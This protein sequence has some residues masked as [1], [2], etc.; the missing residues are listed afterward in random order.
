MIELATR[1]PHHWLARKLGGKQPLPLS[2]TLGLTYNCNAKCKTCDVHSR[3]NAIEMTLAQWRRIFK[4]IGHSPYWITLTGGEPFLFDELVELYYD[5]GTI[6]QPAI[7][8]IPTNGQLTPRIV[9][10]VWDMSKMFP[11]INLVINVSIDHHL[12]YKNDEIRGVPGYT[13]RALETLRQLQE[14]HSNNLTVGI[15]T[16]VSQFNVDELPEIA[17]GLKKHLKY[18]S[19]YIT[20]IAEHRVELNTIGKSITPNAERYS[21]AIECLYNKAEMNGNRLSNIRQ[22]FRQEYYAAVIRYLQ[23][24]QTGIP[25]WAGYLSC[26]ITPDGEIWFCCIKGKSIGNIA[27]SSYNFSA[28]WNGEQAKQLRQT[29]NGCA[30][31]LANVSYT[32]MLINPKMLFKVIRSSL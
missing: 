8:N 32:N 25:C 12:A 11:H 30:C 21:N 6:C 28:L 9:P 17:I 3:K 7:V 27:K 15:H 1:L 20:E 18:P 23:T 19:N 26:Q 16:V 24:R 31:P 2:Y 10:W 4:S 22:S 5:L 14:I 29:L 13:A